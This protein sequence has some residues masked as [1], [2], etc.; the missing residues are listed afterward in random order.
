MKD[1]SNRAKLLQ[2][3]RRVADSYPDLEV[4][5]YED[6]AKFLDLIPTMVPQTIQSSICIFIN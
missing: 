1:W 5:I 6:E 2:Q 4:T 3:W